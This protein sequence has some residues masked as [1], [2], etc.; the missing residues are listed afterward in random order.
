MQLDGIDTSNIIATPAVS[1]SGRPRRGVEHAFIERSTGCVS[2]G[3][4]GSGRLVKSGG[5]DVRG[6]AESEGESEGG[7]ENDELEVE[8]GIES[9]G[10]E[11]AAGAS[12]EGEKA[13]SR[14]SRVCGRRVCDEDESN[15]DESGDEE[16]EREGDGCGTEQAEAAADVKQGAAVGEAVAAAVDDDDGASNCSSPPPESDGSSP[17]PMSDDED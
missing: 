4:A 10:G 8:A 15:D 17:P 3:G 11:G 7:S 16:D 2:R 5:R 12:S 14:R 9:G 1:A 6:G 13:G